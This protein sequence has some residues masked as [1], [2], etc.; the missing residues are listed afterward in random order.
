MFLLI[1]PISQAF[2]SAKI[3]EIIGKDLIGWTMAAYGVS[4][5]IGS[6]AFGKLSD[7]LPKR[8]TVAA[9]LLIV[10]ISVTVSI[11]MNYAKPVL[12]FVTTSICGFADSAMNTQVYAILGKLYKDKPADAFA[13]EFNSDSLLMVSAFKLIQSL[14]TG[15]G[16]ISGAYL[17]LF[18]FQILLL[19]LMF[20]SMIS[21]YTLDIF[22]ERV[23]GQDN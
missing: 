11:V 22:V 7:L 12:F 18:V 23:D 13:G 2:Y 5:I 3:P 6:F 4:E 19:S 15:L 9:T 1:Y 14:A 16:L 21:F 10:T 8:V 20:F 17:P